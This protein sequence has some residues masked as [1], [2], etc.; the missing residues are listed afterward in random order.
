MEGWMMK[1]GPTREYKWQRRW[2]V[3]D[4]ETLA[5]YTDELLKVCKG[6]IPL[7]PASCARRFTDVSAPF[8]APTYG[9]ERPFGFLLDVE[10]SAGKRRRAFYF[11]ALEGSALDA[12]EAAI[13]KSA[14]EVQQ[15]RDRSQE[16]VS[17]LVRRRCY[18]ACAKRQ[19]NNLNPPKR[20]EVHRVSGFLRRSIYSC[21]GVAKPEP[22]KP[23]V[24]QRQ[25]STLVRKS[26]YSS[27]GFK[28]IKVSSVMNETI[29]EGDGDE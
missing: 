13:A 28:D 18:E 15:K 16:Q 23:A 12:W 29:A 19:Q 24:V 2:C 21:V 7:K 14:A 22:E 26:L 10:P 17:K 25:V 3:L 11:D 8:D 20:Q 9:R 1:R 27:A 5:Y 6:E 4:A